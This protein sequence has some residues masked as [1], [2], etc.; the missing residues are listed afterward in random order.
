[1]TAW[2]PI[3]MP[4][5]RKRLERRRLGEKQTL[6]WACR[7]KDGSRLWTTVTSSPLFDP[8]G[9]FF[10]ILGMITDVTARKQAEEALRQSEERFRLAVEYS[11]D[12]MFYQDA[13][14]RFTWFSKFIPPYT[15]GQVI[16]LNDIEVVGGDQGARSSNSR[17]ESFRPAAPN[18]SKT[19]S[20]SAGSF[21]ILNRSWFAAP[22]HPE[23][24]SGWRDISG[25]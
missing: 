23:P 22:I 16:G 20:R 19:P 25:M 1:M 10:G 6:E 24:C 4:P 11:P 17:A 14:L 12:L 21:D 5:F 9:K 3:S 8:A 7:R 15:A 2:T 18:A 13:D